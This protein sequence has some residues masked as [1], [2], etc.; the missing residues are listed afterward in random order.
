MNVNRDNAS[1]RMTH[2]MPEWTRL[3]MQ[4]AASLRFGAIQIVVHEGQVIQVESTER[5]RLRP[6]T[7]RDPRD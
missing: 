4:K 1:E 3:V 7:R 5:I 6:A 2:P